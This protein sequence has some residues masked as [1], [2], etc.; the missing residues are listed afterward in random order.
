MGVFP[1]VTTIGGE[2]YGWLKNGW[3]N[4]WWMNNWGCKFRAM[5][6]K[7]RKFITW[8]D[9]IATNMRIPLPIF[10]KFL[11]TIDMYRNRFSYYS[12]P[13]PNFIFNLY[14]NRNLLN[15][16]NPKAARFYSSSGT[17]VALSHLHVIARI[18]YDKKS[19]V[20]VYN[21]NLGD[22]IC[23]INFHTLL[24]LCCL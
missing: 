6:F 14:I 5:F 24:I 7:I 8:F 16:S 17:D 11:Y 19:F 23:T 18:L 12:N 2:W 3:K 22:N 21:S 10:S 4:E 13:K 9:H 20:Y 1:F 15:F